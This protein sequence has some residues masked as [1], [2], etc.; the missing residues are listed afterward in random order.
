MKKLTLATAALLICASTSAHA[1]PQE[2]V[3][4]K[5]L[6][7]DG[8]FA[9]KEQAV[10]TET[11]KDDELNFLRNELNNVK[12]LKTGYKQKSKV[13]MK[14]SQESEELKDEFEGYLDN[15]VDYEGAISGYN[16]L[17][18]CLKSGDAKKCTAKKKTKKSAKNESEELQL[19]G[20]PQAKKSA[21][22]GMS[23]T[24]SDSL[25]IRQ[26]AMRRRA[27]RG[28]RRGYGSNNF[29]REVDYRVAMRQSDLIS[30]YRKSGLKNEG[31]LKVVLKIAPNGNLNHLGFKDTTHVNDRGLINCVTRVLYSIVYPQ[32]PNRKIVA[33][34]K[35]FVFNKI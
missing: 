19:E 16:A 15:R 18:E 14:L 7:V 24:Y 25:E 22:N 1:L 6:H 21:G 10:D 23:S 4:S 33:V 34:S 31:V 9:N 17:V 32:T 11:P 20:S 12:N 28:G 29:V 35:P 30:C 27:P 3:N 5:T 26:A 2:K 13:Y 8:A